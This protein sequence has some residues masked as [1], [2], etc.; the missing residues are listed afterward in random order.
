M[1]CRNRGMNCRNRGIKKSASMFMLRRKALCAGHFVLGGG[2]MR[3]FVAAISAVFV[4][5]AWPSTTLAAGIDATTGLVERP[6]WE[7]VRTQCGGCHSYGLITNQRGDRQ[8]WLDMIRWMQATQNLWDLPAV[9]EA[10]ILDY[11]AENYPPRRNHRRAP[12]PA[13]LMPQPGAS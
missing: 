6:G 11:L 12:I 13:H 5:A 3:L 1:N 10:A 7:L 2:W 9:T 4:S 8:A